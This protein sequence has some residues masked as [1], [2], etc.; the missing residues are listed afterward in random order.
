MRY[1]TIV[2]LIQSVLL[3]P[4]DL[5]SIFFDFGTM[6]FGTVDLSHGSISI[7]FGDIIPQSIPA[8]PIP[9]AFGIL[10]RFNG[11]T[12]FKG[13]DEM[14]DLTGFTLSFDDLVVSGYSMRA[15]GIT[16]LDERAIGIL[17]N[18]Q[19]D[20]IN[21]SAS[22]A[23]KERHQSGEEKIEEMDMPWNISA[24]MKDIQ[25][26]ISDHSYNITF[27]LKTLPLLLSLQ[28]NTLGI[29]WKMNK[30]HR[31]RLGLNYSFGKSV[32]IDISAGMNGKLSLPNYPVNYNIKIKKDGIDLSLGSRNLDL[33]IVKMKPSIT[34]KAGFGD[35]DGSVR[36][37]I[38][39][40]RL[41]VEANAEYQFQMECVSIR[42]GV[43]IK[44]EGI[45]FTLDFTLEW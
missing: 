15:I 36:I 29:T 44:E 11:T 12:L 35:I 20:P 26:S 34:F 28:K 39:R 5:N 43:R 7:S 41:N 16:K 25:V 1:L 45:S 17:L 22:M 18:A 33:S 30:D 13:S 2:L 14:N 6:N 42:S 32:K 40:N 3:L 4:L 31:F 37:T 10:F 19:M 21:L 38:D 24:R 9:P 27:D 8:L 23:V